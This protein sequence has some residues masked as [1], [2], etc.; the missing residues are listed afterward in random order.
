MHRC[1]Y[2]YSTT[3]PP[4][5][6]RA[7]VTRPP[8]QT[9]SRPH[10]QA[11]LPPASTDANTTNHT[12]LSLL[13][14]PFS[15]PSPR[16]APHPQRL[17]QRVL[18]CASIDFDGPTITAARIDSSAFSAPYEAVAAATTARAAG[19]LQA[20]FR[21][22][23]RGRRSRDQRAREAALRRTRDLA[24]WRSREH[25]QCAGPGPDPS[26]IRCVFGGRG[27]EGGCVCALSLSLTLSL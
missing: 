14:P 26:K 18:H 12:P 10:T 2:T 11:L 24:A 9:A 21:R 13:P 17:G 15:A 16:P 3:A 20:F 5:D 1:I 23:L 27:E 7:W 6:G 25:R 22:S 19:T 8:T 4:S